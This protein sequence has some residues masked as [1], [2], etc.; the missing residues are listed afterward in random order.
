M[1]QIEGLDVLSFDDIPASPYDALDDETQD[2]GDDTDD[3]TDANGEE[4]VD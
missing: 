2:S 4:E 1:Q 3:Y